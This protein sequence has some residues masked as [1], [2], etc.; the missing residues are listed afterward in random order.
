MRTQNEETMPRITTKV[1][2]VFVQGRWTVSSR[3]P[4]F[5]HLI[6]INQNMGLCKTTFSSEPRH[7]MTF[8]LIR[9]LVMKLLEVFLPEWEKGAGKKAADTAE[10]P[11]NN[12]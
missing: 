7:F 9:I 10:K 2:L 5:E 3:L 12:H 11:A 1:I 6:I 4:H 8:H